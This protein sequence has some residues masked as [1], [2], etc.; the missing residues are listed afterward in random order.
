[1]TFRCSVVC[2]FVLA[3]FALSALLA[4]PTTASAN[5]TV[6]FTPLEPAP[7]RGDGVYG[8]FDGD[9]DAAWGLGTAQLGSQTLLATR[10]SL[11]YFS[12]AGVWL[13]AGLPLDS[14]AAPTLAFGVDLRPAFLPRFTEDLQQGPALLDLT[15]DSISLSLGPFF[16]LARAEG[17]NAPP[18]RG[19]ELSLGFGLPLFAEAQGPWLE[20][21]ALGQFPDAR[22][23]NF[24]GLLLISWHQ[25]FHSPRTVR[26]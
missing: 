3:G 16:Q 21:R 1:M 5:E 23:G 15:L 4:S 14:S 26:R 7:S 18:E 6:A 25:L 24:G 20:A 13:S 8:R 11:H 10:T 22:S 2:S 12:T 19:L 9:L 17:S